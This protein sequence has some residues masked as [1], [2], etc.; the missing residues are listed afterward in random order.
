M[1]TEHVKAQTGDLVRLGRHKLLDK[2]GICLAIATHPC[3]WV[4]EPWHTLPISGGWGDGRYPSFFGFSA[5]GHLC[6]LLTEFFVLT[7]TENTT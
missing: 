6:M 1:T 3:S 4:A 7:D 2:A 5:E